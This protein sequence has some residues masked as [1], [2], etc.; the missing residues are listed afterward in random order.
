MFRN[1]RLRW[2]LFAGVLFFYL[3]FPLPLSL[4]SLS[5][6]FLEQVTLS[7][8][9]ACQVHVCPCS[10][11]RSTRCCSGSWST[12]APPS[13]SSR[14]PRRTCGFRPRRQREPWPTPKMSREWGRRQTLGRVSLRRARY[15][16]T[17]ATAAIVTATTATTAMPTAETHLVVPITSLLLTPAH[18]PPSYLCQLQCESVP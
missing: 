9:L 2:L 6:S 5:P 15:S 11:P 18:L 16:S 8:P 12:E 10:S 17:I 4:L 3:S 13:N 14:C 1:E 7:R